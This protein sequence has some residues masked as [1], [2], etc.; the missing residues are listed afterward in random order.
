MSNEKDDLEPEGARQD[1]IADLLKDIQGIDW[2]F[3]AGPGQEELLMV[4][5]SHET[6]V[7]RAAE[8]LL[9]EGWEKVDAGKTDPRNKFDWFRFRI[10]DSL[11]L[12]E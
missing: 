5:E 11:G 12:R 6:P 3:V 7:Q 1:A 10:P 4:M 2:K 9:Q 8:K